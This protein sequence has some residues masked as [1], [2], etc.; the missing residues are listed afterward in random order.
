[1][2]GLV[3][4][5][6]FSQDQ[7]LMQEETVHETVNYGN[8]SGG[9]GAVVNF[10]GALTLALSLDSDSSGEFRKHFKPLPPPPKKKKIEL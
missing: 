4:D 6:V 7:G 9:S 8:L 5:H 10:T 2:V 3:Y 1:V